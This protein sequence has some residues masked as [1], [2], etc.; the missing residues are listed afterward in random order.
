VYIA[1]WED[2][3][4]GNWVAMVWKNGDALWR[5]TNG[6][7]DAGADYMF[8]SGDNAYIAGQESNSYGNRGALHRVGI[9]G[10]GMI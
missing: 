3:A 8:V 2:S 6:K 10:A 7:Y 1:G 5:L 9:N 4:Q